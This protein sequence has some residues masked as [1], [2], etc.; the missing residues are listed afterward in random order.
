MTHRTIAHR[1]YVNTLQH[2]ANEREQRAEKKT[3]V[4]GQRDRAVVEQAALLRT[5]FKASLKSGK[6]NPSEN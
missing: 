6:L 1:T 2:Y 5:L 3:V 4:F